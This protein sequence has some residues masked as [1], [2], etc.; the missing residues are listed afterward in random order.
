MSYEGIEADMLSLG[1]A[2]SILVTRW[3]AGVASRILMDGGNT[4]DAEKVLAFLKKRAVT[5]LDHIVC[6]HPHEDHACGLVGVVHSKDIDFGQA[7]LHLPWK[8]IDG[9]TL[10]T[11][12]TKGEATAKR[13]VKI[14]ASGETMRDNK[15]PPGSS[16]G[17]FL[18]CPA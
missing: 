5:F 2:D 18:K 9:N 14:V 15:K 4:G 11:A 16:G 6:S 10:T 7:W 12:L 17:R 13:V 8:H 1:N 3:K